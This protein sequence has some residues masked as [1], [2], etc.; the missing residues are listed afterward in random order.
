MTPK[1]ILLV[2]LTSAMMFLALFWLL[3]A[4]ALPSY[5]APAT[6]GGERLSSTLPQAP[7]ST[8]RY[9]APTGSDSGNCTTVVSACLTVQY[10]IDQAAEGDEIH[11]A[12]GTYTGV[13]ARD[14]ITQV[15]YISKTVTLRGG[16]S[17][18]FSAWDPAQYTTTLDAQG[19]GRVLYVTGNITPTVEGLHLTHGDA[20]GLGGTPWGHDAGG[21]VY[22]VTA[23]AA[24]S[25]C[26]IVN[27]TASRYGG[28][29][30]LL[31]SPA[32][33]TGNRISGNTASGS[34]GYGGGLSLYYSDAT[35]TNNQVVSNTAG[36]NGGGLHL[37]YGAVTL[38][39]N[40]ISGNTASNRGGGLYLE[41]GPAT[42]TN[43]RI[44]GNTA[45]GPYGYGGGL[46]LSQSDATL[47]GNQIS[48]NTASYDGGGLYLSQSNATLTGNQISGNTASYDGG[49]LYLDQSDADLQND[50][51]ADNMAGNGGGGLYVGGS[52]PVLRHLTLAR[53]DGNNGIYVTRS[54]HAV[55]A[56]TILVSHTVGIHVGS[57][58][59][60][61]LQATLWGSDAWANGSDWSGAGD[62]VTGT[63]NVQGDPGFVNPA[64]GD[65]H[66]LPTSA[67][68]DA[69]VDAG[70][71][72]DID[73]DARPAAFGYDIGADEIPGP[74]LQPAKKAARWLYSLGE[75][76]TYTIR[77]P[78]NGI[79][80]AL[81]VRITDTLPTAQRPQ[82]VAVSPPMTCTQ[83]NSWG[84]AVVCGPTDIPTGAAVLIT[85]TAQITTA[86][87]GDAVIPMNNRL[88]VRGSNAVAATV[89][90]IYLQNCHVRLNDDVTEYNTVQQAVD[91]ASAGDL[92]Q[93]AGVCA[94]VETRNGLSQTLYLSK[95]VTLRGGYSTDFSAWDPAQ[96]TTTL[97]ALGAGRVLYVTG[98]ITPAVERLSLT[99]GDAT[100][101][102]GGYW[103]NDAGGGVYVIAA[104]AAI[105]N[106]RIV[107]NTASGDFGYGGGLYLSHSVATLMGNRVI[108]NTASD[109][110]G[111]YLYQSAATL[112]DNQIGG[113]T[114]YNGG[115]G[116]YLYWSDDATLTN[117]TIVSNTAGNNGG[118][119][120]LLP[121]NAT[122]TDNQVNGNTASHDGG[123]LYLSHGSA[124]LTNNPLDP[125]DRGR[126]HPT[127]PHP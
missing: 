43:N 14:A 26:R 69:G 44:S 85:L 95:T 78:N 54:S 66:I 119:L 71:T 47:T 61:N 89:L 68:V 82:S 24:I 123:G 56:D 51:V 91:A 33:L 32:T 10:A 83:D 52:S 63:I 48:G 12:A 45:S 84:G 100:G 110:G 81:G 98:D 25:N 55:L 46:Y 113:N 118:G 88:A 67:A 59:S 37:S 126:E 28:G 49:G 76:V 19:A 31:N 125:S 11:V 103:G 3:G 60:A 57:G 41:G 101:L 116:L 20:A 94:G 17:T 9:V 104:T 64:A 114:A 1:K 36:Y 7:E 77:V 108:S 16:Y 27:N 38:T 34:Y 87:S 107:G 124:T 120:Y 79:T 6:H 105:S 18:D 4:V 50:I 106:C 15:V 96:Y 35:L 40:R 30:Y 75:T 58:S 22:V 122:L 90:R 121:S 53:N 109:G 29:L 42:L 111:L 5:A 8:T 39:D 72:T 86:F 23:T 127:P 93:V 99:N 97:D 117:N 62:I 115:G 2:A 102:G 70:V 74:A 73:G 92:V 80:T 112:T 21:G 65:Y 13:H